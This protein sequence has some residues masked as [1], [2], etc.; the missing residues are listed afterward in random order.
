MEGLYC[1]M[2]SES[3]VLLPMSIL[4]YIDSTSPIC[5]QKNMSQNDKEMIRIPAANIV[6]TPVS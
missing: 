5:V 4:R 2:I 1:M 3:R 6:R